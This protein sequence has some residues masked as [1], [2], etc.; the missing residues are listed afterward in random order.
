MR[1]LWIADV[2]ADL[3]AFEAALAGATL[4][5]PPVGAAPL[6]ADPPTNPQAIL[7]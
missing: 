2:Y 7:S 6:P 4:A 3:P 5:G 1:R